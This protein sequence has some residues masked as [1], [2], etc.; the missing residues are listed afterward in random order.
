MLDNYGFQCSV[1]LGLEIGHRL[2]I[3]RVFGFGHLSFVTIS[4]LDLVN[5][6]R[7][8]FHCIRFYVA[9]ASITKYR[10]SDLQRK[11]SSSITALKSSSSDFT[12]LLTY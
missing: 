1:Y 5:C 12:L 10:D 11:C 9:G 7:I 6:C 8:L 4:N 2:Q 3:R